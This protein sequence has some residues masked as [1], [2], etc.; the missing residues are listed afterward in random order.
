MAKNSIRD[1]SATASSNT[2]VQSVNIDENCPA[3]GINN[4]IRE[5]MADLAD[6]NAGTVALNSPSVTTTITLNNTSTPST[7]PTS[8]GF[9]FG[10]GGALKYKGSSGTVTTIAVA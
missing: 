2:D 4:A 10:E 1:Y 5:V 7:T 8:S 6:V 9:L 3:S